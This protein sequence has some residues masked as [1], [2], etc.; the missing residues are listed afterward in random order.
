L[1]TSENGSFGPGCLLPPQE[2]ISWLNGLLFA[3]TKNLGAGVFIN[4]EH[5]NYALLAK[6]GWKYL[7]SNIN[8]LWKQLITY[9]Y[10]AF[11]L[12][13]CSPFWKDVMSLSHFISMETTRVCG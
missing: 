10:V 12:V 9:T 11:S 1:I 6:W 13:K 2:S 7:N 3:W 5:M 4:L 8:G